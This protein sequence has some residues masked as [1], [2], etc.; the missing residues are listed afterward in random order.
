MKDIVVDKVVFVLKGKNGLTIT[1]I[2]NLSN[3]SR[4]SVRTSLAKLEGGKK[5]DIR[6]IGMAKVY[7]LRE[8]K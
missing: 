5:V 1:D 7:S 8:L 6:Q 3:L 4:S 2:V